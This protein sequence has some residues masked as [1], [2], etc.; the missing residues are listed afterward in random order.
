MA[1][2]RYGFGFW[3]GFSAL[4][5]VMAVAGVVMA[6]YGGW[7]LL[8]DGFAMSS[9]VLLAGGMVEAVAAAFCMRLLPRWAE[10]V[11]EAR[12]G[13]ERLKGVLGSASVSQY[14]QADENRN[15]ALMESIE[16][17]QND[18]GLTLAKKIE[19]SDQKFT[20]ELQR[21][22]AAMTAKI[23]AMAD[24]SELEH[25]KREAQR[26]EEENRRLKGASI[27]A[28]AGKGEEAAADA[29]GGAG[30]DAGAPEENDEPLGYVSAE[31][32]AEYAM[33]RDGEEEEPGYEEF[34]SDEPAGGA[35]GPESVYW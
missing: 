16:R 28:A 35:A 17:K 1:W 9:S 21:S 15:R 32:E 3:A 13:N 24:P 2:E 11:R 18:V 31:D 34:E 23:A 26:L 29:A 12:M 20:E 6:L 10:M 30:V 4:S 19:R 5:F 25:Y 7:H 22:L 33:M 27:P 8:R 14:I